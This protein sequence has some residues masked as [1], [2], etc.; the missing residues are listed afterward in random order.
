MKIVALGGDGFCGWPIALHLSAQGHEVTI[1]DSLVRRR[2]DIELDALSL[3]PIAPID[4]RLAAWREISGRQIDFFSFDVARDYDALAE[5]I[6]DVRPQAIVHLAEQKA[7]PY[8]M[9][10]AWHKRYTVDNNVSA[11]HNILCAIAESGQDIHVVHIGTMGVYGYGTGYTIPEGYLL[12]ETIDV[13][14]QRRVE[15]EILHPVDPGSVY[16]MTK[17]IDQMLFLYYNKNDRVRIT[18]LHQGIVWGTNTRETN[19]DPRLINRF[20]YDG[21]YGTV[22]NRF[23]VQAAIGHPL[24]VHGSGG[25]TRAF[26]H[27]RDTVRCI[28]L[29]IDHPPRRGE[30]VQ[31]FNQMTEVHS[32]IELANRVSKLT[33]ADIAFVDNPRVEAPRN[34]LAVEAAKLV[35]LGLEPTRLATGLL[36]EVM[37]IAK[38]YANRCDQRRIP[39]LSTWRRDMAPA[40]SDPTASS[41]RPTQTIASQGE[42]VA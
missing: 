42:S 3:T 12:V 14:N 21:D 6:G 8:S 2:V 4:T 36:E 9:K 29:A 20:D 18:D 16:H 13:R 5:V 35:E 41:S 37:D 31:I 33:G 25:Q 23:L 24:T 39:C 27:I 30:R 34:E 40:A 22:L 1:I 38:R 17:A 32:V 26:I 15:R 11:T 19:L 28:E 7:A 10:T